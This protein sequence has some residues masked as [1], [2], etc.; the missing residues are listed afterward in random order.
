MNFSIPVYQLKLGRT[1]RWVTLGLG[2]DRVLDVS[3]KTTTKAQR[4]LVEALRRA[5]AECDPEEVVAFCVPQGARLERVATEITV[6]AEEARFSVSGTFPLIV[7]PRWVGSAER[8]E[9][10]FHPLR[11]TDWFVADPD[12]P[13]DEQARVFF[14]ESWKALDESQ[15]RALRSQGKDRLRTLAFA[16]EPKSLLAQLPEHEAARRH[17]GRGRRQPRRATRVLAEVGVDATQL[18]IEGSLDLGLPREPYRSRLGLLLACRRPQSTLVVGRPQSGKSTL[19]ARAVDDLLETDGFRAHRNADL[20]RHVWRVNVSRLIAGMS[21]VGDWEQRLGDLIADVAGHQRLLWLEDIHLAGQLGR[22]RESDRN[23]AQLFRGPVD[24]GDMIV[25]GE[26]TPEQLQRLEEDAPSFTR[27]FNRVYVEPSSSGETVTIVTA[28]AREIEA[29]EALSFAPTL[30]HTLL[31]LTQ[32]LFPQLAF[33]GKAL[34]ALHALA[35]ASDTPERVLG[36]PELLADLGRQTGLPAALLDLSTP[37]DIETLRARL[38]QR[39]IGQSHAVDA[40][41]ALVERLSAGLTEAG[42]PYAVFLFCGP[43]GTGKTELARALAE[44]LYDS[45]AR[46]LRFDM[47]EYSDPD[48]VARLL[49]DSFGRRGAL[50]EAI[51]QQP[52]CVLLLDEI[53]KAHP[54]VFSMLLQVLDDGRLTDATGDLADFSHAVIVLTSNLGTRPR[55]AG[56]FHDASDGLQASEAAVRQFFAPEF[57]NRLDQVLVFRPLSTRVA[58]LISEKEL[59]RLFARRGLVERNVFAAPTT[60]LVEHVLTHG[61]D[62]S[63]GARTVRRYLDATVGVRLAAHLADREPAR[64][65]LLH[66]S[67]DERGEIQLRSDALRDALPEQAHDENPSLAALRALPLESLQAQL[68]RAAAALEQLIADGGLAALDA[69]ISAALSQTDRPGAAQREQLYWLDRLR[70][71]LGGVLGRANHLSRKRA[72]SRAEVL[73]T[74]AQAKLFCQHAPEI[75]R[76]QHHVIVEILPFGVSSR[77]PPLRGVAGTFID[78]LV[79][80]WLSEHLEVDEY[81]FCRAGT[82]WSGSTVSALRSELEHGGCEELLLRISGLFARELLAHDVGCQ[83]LESLEGGAELVR[84]E[85]TPDRDQRALEQLSIEQRARYEAFLR[86]IERGVGAPAENPRRIAALVRC[87]RQRPLPGVVRK[88][89]LVVQDLRHGFEGSFG[90]LRIAEAAAQMRQLSLVSALAGNGAP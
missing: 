56:F 68:A 58:R 17:A 43:T 44:Y 86:E 22:S 81:L 27:L 78:E 71:A 14:Q 65:E 88:T 25:I 73:Q 26:C 10:A 54:S 12:Q 47:G 34:R 83:L 19:L 80:S 40:V 1:L 37:V 21:Y 52:F 59:A 4:R 57:F 51:R 82:R 67:C 48:A 69:Q 60:A 8:V 41:C 79:Q 75:S 38:E 46:L 7:L 74:L 70:G 24:R 5:V 72:A 66:V 23:F 31:Q 84:I 36:V 16:A 62:A 35:K 9:I 33:P 39:V 15:A 85:V 76:A 87:Y 50:T 3:T 11:Q 30:F 49:G 20:V 2:G 53:E 77:E 42:R 18:A 13:L 55:D 61:F 45:S 90:A 89:E 6:R 29:R 64:L 28:T 32:H 63:L